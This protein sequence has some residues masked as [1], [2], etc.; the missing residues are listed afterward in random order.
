[1]QNSSDASVPRFLVFKLD[2]LQYALKILNVE[3]IVDMNPSTER[4]DAAGKL[5]AAC[6]RDVPVVDLRRKQRAR[7]AKGKPSES[8]HHFVIVVKTEYR[9]KHCVLGLV[10]DRVAEV[11][12]PD[13]NDVRASTIERV[14]PNAIRLDEHIESLAAG[15]AV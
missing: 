1:M 14:L 3:D 10:A 5:A 4:P 9:Q 8:E 7:T 15:C 6:G 11:V 12:D 2:N 13:T